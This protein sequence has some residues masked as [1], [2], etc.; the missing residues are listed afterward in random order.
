MTPTKSPARPPV[1]K[2]KQRQSLTGRKR[3]SAAAVWTWASVGLIVVVVLVIVLVNT[4]GGSTSNV[5]E[6]FGPAS[7]IVVSQASS[8]PSSVF[9]AVGITSSVAQVG[10]FQRVR[11]AQPP[12]TYTV[13]TKKL[14]LFIYW[15]ANFCPYCAATRWALVAALSRFGTFSNLHYMMSSPTDVDPNTRTFTFIGSTYTSKYFVFKAYEVE[16]RNH[17]PTTDQAT[18][19]IAAVVAKYDGSGSFPFL[20]MGNNVFLV[21]APFDPVVLQNDSWEQIAAGLNDPTN[22][23]TQA[24]VAT[25]NYITA[26]ICEMTHNADA[27]VC[28]SSGAQAAITALNKPAG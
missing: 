4:I 22:Y 14:P 23:A 18:G 12:L 9:N 25:A 27:S 16:D 6:N 1:K 3:R 24:I 20:D 19:S 11:P 2:P 21:T 7:P 15:G 26:G 17:A 13:G 8:V 28:A 5:K 10:G